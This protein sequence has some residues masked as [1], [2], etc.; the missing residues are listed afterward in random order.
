[1]AVTDRSLS[2]ACVAALLLAGPA[3][4]QEDSLVSIRNDSVTA[5]L[6]NADLRLAIQALARYLDRPVVLAQIGEVR[7]TLE[8]P[9]PVP[10]EALPDLLRG[11]LRPYGLAL[12]EE[13]GFYTVGPPPPP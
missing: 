12:T 5:R 8:T 6:V 11:M 1:M 9:K 2:T 3:L 10:R 4:A 13:R 7:V